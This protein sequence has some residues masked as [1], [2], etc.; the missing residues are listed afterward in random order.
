[1]IYITKSFQGSLNF[2]AKREIFEN[3]K[4]LRK[5]QTEAEIVLWELLRSRRC[6]GLKFR[7]QHPVKEFI[8]DFY[9]HE[10]LL[11]IEVDGAVHENDMAKE[12]DQNR[13]AE[14]ESF[15]ISI[16]RF[17]NEEVLNNLSKVKSEILNK[18]AQLQRERD[19][20][21]SLIKDESM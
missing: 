21:S 6:G 3:A 13:T 20:K 8:L 18:F 7:R 1:M 10:Y 16:L 12:Y 4:E 9:C 5:N 2:G 14:L 11:G 19:E 15:G 17:K